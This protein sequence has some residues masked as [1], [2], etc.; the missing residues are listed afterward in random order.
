MQKLIL[1][2][3]LILIPVALLCGRPA[4]LRHKEARCLRQAE[5]FLANG[6]RDNA[7]LCARQVLQL[8]VTNVSACLVMAR[9]AERSGSPAALDWLVRVCQLAPTPAHQLNLA[10]CALH[11]ERPPYNLAAR[12]LG[13]LKPTAN[14]LP[15]F[16]V[17]SAELALKL[18]RSDEAA[19]F[20]KE[21][22]RLEPR[23]GLH[24]LNLAVLEL[25]ST[26]LAQANTARAV[27]H[28]LSSDATLGPFALRWLKADALQRGK[29]AEA[30]S[31]SV[32]LIAHPRA[33][34]ADQLDYL[35]ILQLLSAGVT[36]RSSP[37]TDPVARTIRS[38]AGV[39]VPAEVE[40]RLRSIQ[41][42]VATNALQVY[43]VSEWMGS[44]GLAAQGLTWVAGLD[45]KLRKRQ[46]LPLAEAN[47]Y[48]AR[49]DWPGL[50][51]FLQP[52]NWGE[53]EFL[54]LALW[55]RAAWGQN[56]A[57]SG[58][59][60]WSG[61]V[62]VADGLGALNLLLGLASDWG[63]ESES[64]LWQIGRRYPREDWAWN[65]LERR[66]LAGGNTRGLNRVAGARIQAPEGVNDSTNRNNF[67]ATSLLLGINLVQAHAL[68]RE[69]YRHRPADLL[70]ASTYAYS[71]HLQGRTAEALAVLE[72][73]QARI[74]NTPSVALYYGLLLQGAG[75]TN[76]ARP[77]L[78]M[79]A[80][81]NLLPEE[82]RLLSRARTAD[83]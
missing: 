60:H 10:A 30:E 28:R 41:A 42:Q 37:A 33:Q 5:A 59:A 35:A 83:F 77:F 26:N 67:A 63:A 53:L 4:Y 43:W 6:D 27:L 9:L 57:A 1:L 32:R 15:A 13:G 65:E 23:N 81:T 40:S 18:N 51:R 68:A 62:R 36:N 47:L 8:N 61:A 14:R 44:H 54:R 2:F 16:Q 12:A 22:A 73:F 69:L 55:A 56:R 78:E 49:E 79:A 39:P 45:P 24:R 58:Q 48:L 76:R 66:Y 25:Q 75:Q 38:L 19:E 70:S 7:S 11:F 64:I 20:F 72:R 50:E 21:A 52:Q 34:L 29:A 82:Q 17:L 80:K 31:M 46:P 71:L 3:G 74:I